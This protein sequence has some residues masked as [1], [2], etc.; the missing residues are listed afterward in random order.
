MVGALG[1]SLLSNYPLARIAL[2]K[3]MSEKELEF[4]LPLVYR[5]RKSHSP[6]ASV[7][8][9]RVEGA[10]MQHGIPAKNGE[11]F[12]LVFEGAESDWTQGVHLEADRGVSVEKKPYKRAVVIPFMPNNLEFYISC[13]TREGILWVWN[14]WASRGVQGESRLE[15]LVHFAGM[16]VQELPNGYRYKCNEGRD[17]DDYNDLVFRIERMRAPGHA[18]KG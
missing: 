17:D 12:R 11:R 6:P 2:S 18:R 13:R 10:R 15:S 3:Q 5:R 1:Y 8:P 16:L 7:H 14:V 4:L 9:P